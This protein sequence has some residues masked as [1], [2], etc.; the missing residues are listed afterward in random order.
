MVGDDFADGISLDALLF[1]DHG[2]LDD[3]DLLPLTSRIVISCTCA[4]DIPSVS[5]LLSE[6]D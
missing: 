4:S 3:R 1:R 6:V 5:R 2:L